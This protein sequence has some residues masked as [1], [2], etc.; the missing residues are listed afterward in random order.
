MSLFLGACLTAA[1]CS[2]SDKEIK[3]PTP[4]FPEMTSPTIGAGE[5]CTIEIDPNQNWEVSIPTA[6]AAWFW[7]EDGTQKVWTRRGSA[8]PAQIVIGAAELEEFDDNRVCEVTMTMG[9]QS[10]VIATITRGTLDRGFSL[11]TCQLDEYGDF[12][13]NPNSTE[14]GLT[15]LYNTDPA[16]GIALTWPEGRTGF[17][18]PILVDGNFQWVLS[19]LP[20]WLEVPAKTI[21]EPGAKLELR[22]LGDASRYPLDGAEDTLVFTDKSNAEVTY[23]IPISIPACRDIFSV[24][25][26]SAETKFNAKAEYFNSMNGD[27][28]PGNAMGSIQSI[29]G[30]KLFLFSEVTQ[31]WGDPY[32]S[33]EA[34]DV[35]WILLTEKPWDDTPG[36][37]VVQSRSITVGVTENGGDAR[38]AI[39]L[40]LPSAVAETISDPNELID[41]DIRDEYKQYIVTTINQEA[42]PGSITANNPSGMTEI[43]AAFEK[44]P[45][46][47]WNIGEFGVK[48]GYKL[49]YTKEWSN[50]P[51]STLTVDREYTDIAYFDYDLQPM[52]SEESWLSVRKT[53]EGIIIDMD[54]SKDK[55]GDNSMANEGIAHMGFIVFSDADGRFALIQSIYDENY[56]IGGGG[57]GFEVKF[58]MPDLVSGATLVEITK[59]NYETVAGGNTDLLAS[60]AENLGMGVPQYMLTY[61]SAEPSNAV[62]EVSPYQ[63]IML[64]P[65]SGAEWLDYEPMSETQILVSM[66]KP[67]AEQAPYGMLQFMDGSWNMKCIVYCMP[68]F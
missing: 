44:L 53:A 35:K 43:G 36:S 51:E 28:V 59:E 24:S 20:E 7:I 37:D 65:M 21:G 12:I 30:A 68:A 15:Y 66:A 45:A 61:T 11:R 29:K 46:N 63:Q 50:D 39:L 6:T 14:T 9:G 47:D 64:M 31:Q 22:L 2:D 57:D 34:E 67:E 23:E 48:D 60:F 3:A 52:S 19:K 4:N 10:K 49:I 1:S 56:P 27:W 16:E 5:T 8:G 41:M 55:C 25:G 54:P 38:K 17:S 40:A 33:A 58:A 62:L 13:Y 42:Y 32:L 18:M 26:L